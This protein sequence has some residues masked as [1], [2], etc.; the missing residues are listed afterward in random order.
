M[1]GKPARRPPQKSPP[2]GAAR[3]PGRRQ[4][5]GSLPGGAARRAARRALAAP[6]D[7]GLRPLRPGFPGAGRAPAPR[8]AR[9]HRGRRLCL[10][11]RGGAGF[12]ASRELC[13]LSCS[14][15]PNQKANLQASK[16]HV[17]LSAGERARPG[18]TSRA[19][20]SS[21]ADGGSFPTGSG[22]VQPHRQRGSPA[23][24]GWDR[25]ARGPNADGTPS[26]RP[27]T[28][29]PQPGARCLPASGNS[30]TAARPDLDSGVRSSRQQAGARH[31]L[32]PCPQETPPAIPKLSLHQTHLWF[33]NIAGD[34]YPGGVHPGLREGC[35]ERGLAVEGK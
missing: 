32:S 14:E 31:R 19:C 4:R 23:A 11:A 17:A 18:M 10:A 26:P 3:S 28:P 27:P 33:L 20:F 29:S 12:W 30:K 13:P 22:E 21:P 6:R 16:P 24:P 5:G 2:A 7:P 25:R 35:G 1:Q 9:R 34:D 15:K 8:L